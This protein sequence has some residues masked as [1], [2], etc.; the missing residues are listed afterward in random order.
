MLS[1]EEFGWRSSSVMLNYLRIRLERMRKTLN[2]SHD[3]WCPGLTFEMDIFGLR[4][5]E[6]HR[7]TNLAR[8]VLS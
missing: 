5:L 8:V 6:R 1:R 3:R 4:V 2:L 7:C